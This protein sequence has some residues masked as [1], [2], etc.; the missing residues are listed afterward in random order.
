MKGT[1]V[2]VNTD[3][4]FSYKYRIGTYAY[5][6]KGTGKH[7]HGSGVFKEQY[8]GPIRKGPYDAEMKA[9]INAL[10]VIKKT[11]HPPIIGFIFN[12]DNINAK[13][14]K[15]GDP[16]QKHLYREIKWFRKDAE[17]RLG[18]KNFMLLTSKQ[19]I[20]AD[21]R[22]V[23]AHNGT[24]DKRS[25]VNDWCDRQCKLRFEEWYNK[26]VKPKREK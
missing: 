23:K 3:A 9:I 24:S 10:A 17:R 4:G 5:W 21:F 12:R 16:L 25:Y 6:I 18:I 13:S 14:G 22:H 8:K 20:Y 15:N 7:L 11:G 1:F 2:T 19:K 26:N